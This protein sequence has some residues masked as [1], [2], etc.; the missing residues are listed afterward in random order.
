MLHAAVILRILYCHAK[1]TFIYHEAEHI[2]FSAETSETSLVD[3]RRALSAIL[4]RNSKSQKA[5][6]MM[7]LGRMSRNKNCGT[8]SG[9]LCAWIAVWR[10]FTA[11]FF[12][13][14]LLHVA[15]NMMAFLPAA[16]TLERTLGT[17]PFV[18]LMLLLVVFGDAAYVFI[19]FATAFGPL[20]KVS[21]VFDA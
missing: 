11:P 4:T 20:R 5:Q 10:F 19:S 12:H 1:A 14:G 2:R 16:A 15:F 6:S 8:C 21:D 18:H 7:C 17:I 9:R 13:V 3:N